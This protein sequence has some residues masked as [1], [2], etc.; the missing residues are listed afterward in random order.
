MGN[1]GGKCLPASRA[2]I[3]GMGGGSRW[4]YC[5]QIKWRINNL[6]LD[7]NILFPCL[8]AVSYFVDLS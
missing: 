8:T 1:M 6:S 4:R 5:F 2:A 7:G 3:D